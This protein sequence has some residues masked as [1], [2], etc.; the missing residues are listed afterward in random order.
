MNF[1]EKDCIILG[2]GYVGKH[3]LSI[4]PSCL[5]TQRTKEGN[6]NKGLKF[7]LANKETWE[8]LKNCK[9]VLWTF[10]LT[11]PILNFDLI[12]EFYNYFCKDKKVIILSS[13]SAFQFNTENI[14]IDES[15]PLQTEDQRYYKEEYLRKMGAVILHLSG[16][17][18][19][20]RYPKKWYLEK[21]VKNGSNILNYIHVIDIIYFIEKLF[22]LFIPS[23]R[24]ILSSGDT[25]THFEIASK[26]GL[27]NSFDNYDLSKGSKIL[28]NKKIIKYLQEEN[29]KFLKYPEDC[30][31]IL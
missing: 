26:L 24:F 25:K 2:C 7:D 10:S 30:E 5:F 8:N 11:D 17:I 21:R 16:I 13:T 28:K 9:F 1:N 22:S 4:H 23:E 18:G 15:F 27:E 3:F 20:N 19:P 6:S 12:N 29:Y 14:Q 31:V